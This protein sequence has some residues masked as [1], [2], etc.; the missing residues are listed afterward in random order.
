VTNIDR[1]DPTES[2]CARVLMRAM[3]TYD[4]ACLLGFL[5]DADEVIRHAAAVELQFRPTSENLI[6][7]S[8][9]CKSSRHEHREA[10]AKVLGQFGT[11]D[12]PFASESFELLYPLLSDAYLEVQA[13]ALFAVGHI[14]GPELQ[15]TTEIIKSMPP[16]ASSVHAAVRTAVAFALISVRLDERRAILTMLQN[17]KIP[18]VREWADVAVDCDLNM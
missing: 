6:Q 18:E 16:M 9:L 12:R 11:P 3:R 15:P 13:A 14:C 5:K 17:D 1:F 8:N 7:I 2:T 4:D 10:A